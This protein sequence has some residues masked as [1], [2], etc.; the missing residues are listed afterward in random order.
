MT[1]AEIAQ[2]DAREWAKRT[3][4]ALDALDALL[5]EGRGIAAAIDARIG[6]PSPLGLAPR[7]PGLSGPV[8]AVLRAPELR[9]AAARWRS[10]KEGIR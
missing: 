10:L 6:E 4:R 7:Y 2:A 8:V 1:F 9:A 5:A 3:E